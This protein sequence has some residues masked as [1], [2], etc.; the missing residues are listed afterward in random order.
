MLPGVPPVELVPDRIILDVPVAVRVV[1]LSD[2]HL[3][4]DSTPGPGAAAER[5][6]HLLLDWDGPG[7]VVLAGDVLELLADPSVGP[8]AVVQAHRGLATAARAFAGGPDRHLLYLVGNHDGQLAWDEAAANLVAQRLGARLALSVDLRVETAN[9]W[10]TVRIEHGHRLDPANAF[11]DARNPLDTPLGH[12]VA[13][14]VPSVSRR[15]GSWLEGLERLVEPTAFPRMVAS[16]LFYRRL[17]PWLWSLFV[18][19]AAALALSTRWHP[20]SSGNHALRAVAAIEAAVVLVLALATVALAWLTNRAWSMVASPLAGRGWGQNDA[21]RR[22]ADSLAAEGYAGLVV[23]HT[24]HA[25]LSFT[26]QAFYANAGCATDMVDRRP[27]RR[28]LPVVFGASRQTSWIELE[29]GVDLEVRLVHGCLPLAGSRLER[30]AVRRNRTEVASPRV[31]ASLADGVPWPASPDPA[32]ALRRARRVAAV[33]L[34][35]VGLLDIASAL[36]PPLRGRL[37]LL[38]EFMPLFVPQTAASLVGVAGLALVLLAR[39]VRRGQRQA[40]RLSVGLLLSSAAL[41]VVKGLAVEE[42]AVTVAVALYLLAHRRAFTNRSDRPSVRRA[43]LALSVGPLVASS[44]ATAVV[45]LLPFAGRPPLGQAALA[46]AERLLG[47]TAI[48]LPSEPAEF[49]TPTLAAIGMSLAAFG[50][51]VLFRPIVSGHQANRDLGRARA[52]V[53]RWGLETLAFFALRDDKEH[54]FLGDSLVAYGL[55]NGVCLVSPDPIGPPHERRL[56]WAAFRRF[57]DQ[58]GWAVAVL[59]ATEEWLPVYRGGGMHAMYVG[60]EGIVDCQA[61]QL[62][63][64]RFKGL[65]QAVNRVANKGYRIEFHDPARLGPKMRE[66]LLELMT[67][68]RRGD[69]ERG[70]S[71]TLGR[72]F[73]PHDRGLLLAVALGPDGEPAAFAQF[74]PAPGID[75]Y[76]LDLMRRSDGDH[77]NGLTDFVV[78]KTI[79]HLRERGLVGLGLN[80]ATMRAVL[81]GELGSSP[82]QRAQRWALHQLS[83]SMQIESL[84]R[85]NA[86]FAPVWAPRYAVYDAPEHLLPI[87][88]AVGRAESF[89]ELPVI[90]RFLVPRPLAPAAPPPVAADAAGGS[91]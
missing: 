8:T 15:A 67:K 43:L 42:A 12:H 89:W 25:E 56:V 87:A 5:L 62:G 13:Q 48:A 47:I 39:G 10:R 19:P 1:V 70:F 86:K 74:V 20:G 82:A 37:S 72:V 66:G 71:M 40:W 21:G 90:G 76:S 2:L 9:G 4:G 45:E 29:G 22:E 17:G 57:A 46:M 54:F 31:V 34:A 36:S 50:C 38:L 65:R 78:V 6:I 3:A 88:L 75:G 85:Y 41:D 23:G 33:I 91:P 49:L 28:G 26:G 16:R 7:V 44:V 61:F 58:Q 32:R 11:T 53:R 64:G 18:P 60:D 51:W 84:W 24:H 63:G 73:D 59:G 52:I 14:L 55:I 30:L 35:A 77:P 81:A 79:E 69:V 27:T 68:S 80:F 83:G